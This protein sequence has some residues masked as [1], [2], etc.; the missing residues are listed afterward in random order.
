MLT[1]N[2]ENRGFILEGVGASN[3]NTMGNLLF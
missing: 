1:E 3:W 2:A